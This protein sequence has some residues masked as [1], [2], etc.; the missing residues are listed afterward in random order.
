M[1]SNLL[2]SH[3]RA[4]SLV[5]KEDEENEE[6]EVKTKKKKKKKKK[7]GN[8]HRLDTELEQYTLSRTRACMCDNQ[9][10]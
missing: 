6:E 3:L 4:R 10:L 8:R 2:L 9:Q 7:K 5:Y 1:K